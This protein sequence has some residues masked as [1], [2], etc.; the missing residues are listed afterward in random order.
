MT[1]R[2]QLSTKKKAVKAKMSDTKDKILPQKPHVNNLMLSPFQ[3]CC[4]GVELGNFNYVDTKPFNATHFHK[5]NGGWQ[6]NPNEK[7]DPTTYE[8]I[9]KK[10]MEVH[11]AL[12]VATTGAGQEYV[13][14]HLEKLGFKMVYAFINPGHANTEVKLW[15]RAKKPV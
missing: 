13:E 8:D 4:G 3:Y 10:L 7:D 9:E 14:P 6:S 5:K 12:C 2:T 11:A 1:T 15:A